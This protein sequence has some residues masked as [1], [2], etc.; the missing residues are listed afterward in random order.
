MPSL[1]PSAL[2]R[3][4]SLIRLPSYPDSAPELDP[5]TPC[6]ICPRTGARHALR[7]GDGFVDL[8]SNEFHPT[9]TQKLLDSRVTAW[10]YDQVR[11]RFGSLI[12]IPTFTREVDQLVERLDLKRGHTVLDI[13]CGQG[14]F[15]SMLAR[16]VGPEGL[17]I[18]IDIA[19]AM[20]RRAARRIEREGLFNVLL[21]RGDALGMPFADA[22]FAKVNC[23]GG[24]HQFPDLPRALAEM[25]RVSRDGGSLTLSGFAMQSPDRYASFKRWAERRFEASF[26]LVSDVRDELRRIGYQDGSMSMEGRWVG[27]GWGHLGDRADGHRGPSA[28]D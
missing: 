16:H 27:Y 14:N 26:P 3:A 24:M 28:T 9:D 21:I 23:S 19:R 6:L 22:A 25:A 1:K 2:E 5:E 15:T 20:L 12:G 13:A 11:D 4:H 17:V 8:L 18:G 7:P 10:A